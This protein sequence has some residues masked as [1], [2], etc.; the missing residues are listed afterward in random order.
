MMGSGVRVPS[1]A[2]FFLRWLFNIKALDNILFHLS[3]FLSTLH[4]ALHLLCA[5][6]GQIQCIATKAGGGDSL[7]PLPLGIGAGMEHS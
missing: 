1:A 6:V 3:P 5:A 7:P 2:P 4:A